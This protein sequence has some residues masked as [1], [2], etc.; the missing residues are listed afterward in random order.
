MIMIGSD[1][2]SELNSFPNLDILRAVRIYQGSPEL[3]RLTIRNLFALHTL[4]LSKLI[5]GK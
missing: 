4:R 3:H 2:F 1:E 5:S